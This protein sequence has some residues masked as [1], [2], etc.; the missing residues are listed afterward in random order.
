MIIKR[1]FIFCIAVIITVI[2]F[3]PQSGAVFTGDERIVVVLDP[4]HGGTDPGA[5]GIRP[6]AYYNL[7]VALAAKAKLEE[8]GNFIVH[9]S[10]STADKTL[11]IAERLYYA[12]TVNADVVI[13]IHFNSSATS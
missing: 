10:R 8:N 3:I 9:I 7:E 6:E 12:D 1:I 5:A 13:S 4:G 2:P 11:T